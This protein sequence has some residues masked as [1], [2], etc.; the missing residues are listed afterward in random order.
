MKKITAEDT[1][2]LR[3]LNERVKRHLHKGDYGRDSEEDRGIAD[4]RD[5]KEMRSPSSKR[6][7]SDLADHIDSMLSSENVNPD[8]DQ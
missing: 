6:A 5:R 3:D 2:K 7:V 1:R 8:G 4:P